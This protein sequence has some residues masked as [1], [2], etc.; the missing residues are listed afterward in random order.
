[1]QISRQFPPAF[2]AL[3]AAVAGV[4]LAILSVLDF[5]SNRQCFVALTVLLIA[6]LCAEVSRLRR[7]HP[8][9][10]LL[11]PIVTCSLVTFIINYA[12]TNVLFFAPENQLELVGLVPQVSPAMV[13]LMWLALL[14][15]VS[16]WLGYWSPIAA[17]LSRPGVVAKFQACFL[18]KTNSLVPFALPT[19]L[20]IS[21]GVRLLQIQL[22]VFGYSSSYERLIEM[23][24]VTQ[25][26]AMGSKLGKLALLLAALQYYSSEKN[27]H[28]IKW[29]YGVLAVEVLFGFISGF[30]SAVVTPFMLLFLCQYL[31]TR[32]IS[33]SWVVL[34]LVAIIVA[35]VVVEPFRAAR[36]ID[37]G[38][39]GT[40]IV[41]IANTLAGATS[42]SVDAATENAPIV[43]SIAS[44]SNL[45]YIGSFGISFSDD[46]PSLPKDSPEFLADIFFAPLHA[47]IPRLIWPTKPLG[48][49]GLWYTQV[50]LGMEHFSATG[51]GPFTYLYFAGGFIAVILAF[52]FIGVVQRTL[53]FLLHR[54]ILG[55]AGPAFLTMLA[56]LSFI[57]SDFNGLIVTLCR[58]LPIVMLLQFVLFRRKV[59]RI[60]TA[61][62]IIDLKTQE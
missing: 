20:A 21:I 49:Q 9:C 3:L 16:M 4:L 40:S 37:A 48:I 11:N 41:S 25:Y 30:K 18:P 10:W 14:G 6:Y 31:C 51:M 61:F 60:K 17:R 12:V 27:R 23:G 53:F 34:S 24:A 8:D 38:F 26:L 7:V 43:L 15:A 59:N 2:T 36:N 52:F 33:K 44:R 5:L 62:P 46:N 32:K 19:L 54:N 57:D 58:E 56:T 29:L 50:V 42:A 39:S 13:K 35:Y 47:W 45:S 1:M 55:A 22:G 28:A